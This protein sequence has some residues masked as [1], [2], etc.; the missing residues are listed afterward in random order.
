[1]GRPKIKS[2]RDKAIKVYYSPIEVEQLKKGFSES[3]CQTLTQ[4]VRD[5]SLRYPFQIHR[6]RAFDRFTEEMIELRKEMQEIRRKMFITKENEIRLI[7]LHEE[8]KDKLNKLIDLCML[9]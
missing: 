1:M 3:S 2:H 5:L 6:N 7:E 4:Y 9:K 8:I